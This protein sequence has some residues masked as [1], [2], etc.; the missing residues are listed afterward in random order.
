MSGRRT[1]GALQPPVSP[2]TSDVMTMSNTGYAWSPVPDHASVNVSHVSE[3]T[4]CKRRTNF[5]RYIRRRHV[6]R[7]CPGR[8]TI[9]VRENGRPLAIDGAKRM[10]KQTTLDV[11]RVRNDGFMN[12][13]GASRQDNAVFPRI[14]ASVRLDAVSEKGFA[15]ADALTV[16]RPGLIATRKCAGGIETFVTSGRSRDELRNAKT[17]R[18]ER[19][20]FQCWM[21]R[22]SSGQLLGDTDL[23]RTSSDPPSELGDIR[24]G[25]RRPRP[26]SD[27]PSSYRRSFHLRPLQTCPDLA[28]HNRHTRL[29][30]NSRRPNHRGRGSGFL[31]RSPSG[32][33]PRHRHPHPSRVS[34]PLAPAIP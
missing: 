8:R 5:P 15:D 12:K 14:G 10:R 2:E 7:R 30:P 22:S 28:T 20:S 16:T 21:G 23:A 31:T 9:Q 11:C 3:N 32:D 19:S 34:S 29:T 18:A 6:L 1:A 33:S 4:C 17:A 27:H 25:T 26:V 24:A 13:S